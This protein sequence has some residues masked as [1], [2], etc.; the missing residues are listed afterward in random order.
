MTA[1]TKNDLD[2]LETRLAK[3]IKNQGTELRQEMKDQGTELRQEIK[4]QGTELRKEIKHSADDVLEVI[5][6]LANTTHNQ[7]EGIRADIELIKIELSI[8]KRAANSI[9]SDID[10]AFKNKSITEEETTAL[11]AGQKRLE[12]WIEQIAKETGIKLSV[13]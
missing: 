9:N 8:V 10:K 1:I 3:Q 2:S 11:I 4:N 7:L 6:K 5:G 12:R 13:S